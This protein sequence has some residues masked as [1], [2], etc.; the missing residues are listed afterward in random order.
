MPLTR[1]SFLKSSV[2][3]ASE[4]ALPAMA[5]A[6]ST[7]TSA[8]AQ[9]AGPE[10]TA[11]DGASVTEA[12]AAPPAEFTRGVGIYPGFAGEVSS[13]ALRR[14]T[15]TYRN[16]ALRRAARHSSS[17]DYNLTAQLITDGIRDT[18][19]PR[20]VAVSTSAEGD[21]SKPNREIILDHFPP[22]GLSL[23]GRK[24]WVQVQTMGGSAP[25]VVD[26]LR[27]FATLPDSLPAKDAR[28][29]V[30]VSEDGRRWELAG[31]LTAPPL[32]PTEGYPPDLVQGTHLFYPQ[33]PLHRPGQNRFYRVIC[34]LL[35]P[36]VL[37]TIPWMIGQVEFYHAEK[38]VPI[39]G[40]SEFTSAW[41]SA[42]SGEEWVSVDLGA[43]CSIDRI[44]LYWIAR[45][46]EG[47]IQVSQDEHTWTDIYPLGS[48]VASAAPTTGRAGAENSHGV[49]EI[50][51]PQAVE[52]RY[53][54]VWMSRPATPYGYILSELEVWG[55]GGLVPAP[56]EAAPVRPPSTD[57][58][59]PTNI[60]SGAW[61]VERSSV[62]KS[63]GHAISRPGFR[64]DSWLPASVP[65]SVLT[66]F[67]N[68]GAI[69]D[70]NFGENQLY[71]SDSYFCSDFWYRTEFDTPWAG[72]DPQPERVTW[73]DFAGINWK[74]R[75]FLN[76]E[77]LGE[78]HGGFLHKRFNVTGKLR[79]GKKN[80]LAVWIEKNQTPGSTKQKTFEDPS[81]NGGALGAD[82]PTFHA[83]IGWDWI[84]TIR[85]RNTGIWAPITLYRT[86]AV[87]LEEPF[88]TSTLP[89]PDTS[90]ASIL[91]QGKLHNHSSRAVRATLRAR[92]GSI[93]AQQDVHL[94]AHSVTVAG[95]SPSAYPDLLIQQPRLWW[96]TGYGEPYLYPVELSLETAEGAVL[97]GKKFEFG[98]RQMTYNEDGGMLKIF[99]NG[100]R[101]ICR[102]G[103]WGFSESMLR[104]RAREYEAAVR[105][106]R[107]MNFTMIRNWVGQVGEE[108]FYEACDRNGVMVWQDFWL[109]NPWDGPNPDNDSMFM[110]NA[111]DLL[112]RIRNHAS[113]GLY[114][115]RN[116]GYPP[117]ALDQGLRKALAELHPGIQYIP[118]S[119]DDVVSGHGPYHALPPVEYFQIADPLLHSE[120]G[121]PN[122]P[123]M[124]SVR[125]MMPQET[126]WPQGLEWGLH[127]FCLK[128]AQNAASFRSIIEVS[129]GGAESVEEWVSLAQFVNFEGYRAMFESQSRYRAGLLLWMS[130]PCWPSFV[131]QTYDYFFEPTAAYFG[132]KLASEP[133][134][135]QW[136]R[137]QETVE[138]VNYSAGNRRDLTASAEILNMNG[139]RLAIKTIALESMEDSTVTAMA[140]EYPQGLSPVHF[141]RLRLTEGKTVLSAN[142]YMRG[143]V[144]GDYRAIRQLAK[145]HVTARTTT[146]RL[147]R[148]WMLTT[149][150]HNTSSWPSLMT[151]L[152]AVRAQSGDRILPAI[153]SENYLML[154]PGERR[155]VT[156]ELQQAD[157][158]G[159]APAIVLGGFNLVDETGAGEPAT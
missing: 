47:K 89:L 48:P 56:A 110:A 156:T 6:D 92:F 104:Y 68:A 57:H 29:L 102:G 20:W 17:Y 40:P 39:G 2:L 38:R 120:I 24:V 94:P 154:M 117:K 21:L 74:A 50:H 153:Y 138:V 41:M 43:A 80:A 109:A 116:E 87:T 147:G 95:F 139:S 26:R 10:G 134:H 60:T 9:Q 52:A 79:P 33:L 123:P 35:H 13:P 159:E 82:N 65:G 14:D 78:I 81:R 99:I 75:I 136:N 114:C 63:D 8:A 34:E 111:R 16:L 28:I 100:R 70:P 23:E 91:I 31:E 148:K 30:E 69:A 61:R 11:A 85:G 135:I 51:L 150:L 137:D 127:D 58:S 96:P 106:H 15:T 115:G 62:V 5:A 3:A 151:R 88:V 149:V 7:S 141:L 4:M 22:V 37:E 112:L 66:S 59:V 77:E 55:R 155:T 97:D 132:C 145:A 25:P 157:T 130:H 45:A 84:P 53:V 90:Q 108:A 93:Q 133:L 121:M 131:W 140:M 129:Y 83:S 18:A 113:I 71:I 72:D 64:D 152:K 118:S 142:D 76:G 126:L 36:P 49:E 146:E 46:A 158:R 86:G 128:G 122:I 44:A 107:E 54:R 73:L 144:E 1:R 105:Y 98:I 125:R 143:L 103:N 67:Y 101:F 119:A 12:A 42:G 19:L 27:V 124:E 32:A